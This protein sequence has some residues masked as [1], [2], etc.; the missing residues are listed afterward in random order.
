[1]NSTAWLAFDHDFM[2]ATITSE[3]T[4]NRIIVGSHNIDI[5]ADEPAVRSAPPELLSSIET[6]AMF[7]NTTHPRLFRTTVEKMTHHHDLAGTTVVPRQN[8]RHVHRAAA[9]AHRDDH[10]ARHVQQQDMVRAAGRV[11][12]ILFE[13]FLESVEVA[14]PQ[15]RSSA[16][17]A[18]RMIVLR[19]LQRFR[20]LLG[21]AVVPLPPI[22]S[23]RSSLARAREPVPCTLSEEEEVV[24]L[25]EFLAT[26]RSPPLSLETG[27][28]DVEGLRR[29]RYREP[30]APDR[31]SMMTAASMC[32]AHRL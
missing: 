7:M 29:R 27:W 12:T 31:R 21:L 6:H 14:S 20:S 2:L 15:F 26:Y 4:T 10:E 32:T 19:R 3:D 16:V 9:A 1:M 30:E 23:S 11:P 25:A 13:L 24:L 8:A 17:D 28:L 18:V 22:S 5:A